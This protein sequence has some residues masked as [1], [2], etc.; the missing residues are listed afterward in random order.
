LI[1]LNLTTKVGLI[2]PPKRPDGL[3]TLPIPMT[4]SPATSPVDARP[5]ARTEPALPGKLSAWESISFTLAHALT[6]GLLALLSLRGLYLFGRCFGTLE[7]LIDYRRRRRFAATLSRVL[8]HE[9]TNRDRRRFTR[10]FFMRSRCDKLLY[11][12]IDCVPRDTARALL[13]IENRGLLEEA[14]ARGRGVYVALSHHGAHHILAMLLALNDFKT[15]GVR[16]RN[17]GA[18]RRYVQSRFDRRYPEFRRLRVLFS[19]AFPRDIYRC[20]QDG[21][22]LGSAMDV[23]RLRNTSQKTETVSIFGET[24]SFLSGPLHV[25]IRCRSPVLQAFIVPERDFRYRFAILETLI[26]PA[27]VTDR[28]HAVATAMETYAANVERYVRSFPALLSRA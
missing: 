4:G 12:V 14:I 1:V 5:P 11:L 7:W 8:G 27:T 15:A 2:G 16:D 3:V 19:D 9:A 17:E 25:A 28:D 6:A 13:T 18:L 20:L 24:R 21:Y 10:E 23:S 26:D 22:M